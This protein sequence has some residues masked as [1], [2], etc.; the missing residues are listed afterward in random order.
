[1][2]IFV[3]NKFFIDTKNQSC[4]QKIKEFVILRNRE[5][6]RVQF[7]G[8]FKQ[9]KH[10]LILSSN[11]YPFIKTF[12]CGIHVSFFYNK[13][14]CKNPKAPIITT[15]CHNIPEV[16]KAIKLKS[17]F[18]L[19]SPVFYTRSHPNTKPLGLQKVLNVINKVNYN[20]FILLGGMNDDKFRKV[21]LLD[22]NKKIK[23]F[24]GISFKHE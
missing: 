16:I 9:N 8:K 19:L 21:Q 6:D 10:K 20:N 18:I 1:M 14:R 13:I 2:I 23:G 17:R 4:K 24:A 11:F 3:Y 15:S 22:F 12:A 5:G 7:N